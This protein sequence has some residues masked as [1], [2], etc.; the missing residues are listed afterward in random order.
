MDIQQAAALVAAGNIQAI[1]R[2]AAAGAWDSLTEDDKNTL[3]RAAARAGQAAMLRH[4]FEHHHMYATDPDPRGRTPLHFAA[5][6]GDEATVRFAVDVLG[7]DPLTGDADGRTAL[8]YAH[9]ADRQA[10]YAWLTR[11]LGFG[12][13]DAYRNPILRGFH[14]DPSILR[15]GEDYYIVNSSFVHFPGLPISHSRD[16]V[17]WQVIGHAA[18]DLAASGLAGLPGGYGYWA[19]D[20]SYYK[21]RFWV[22]AT[23]RRHTPP[24]RLQMITSAADPRGPWDKPRFLPLDGIDPS[25]FADDDGRRY[26]LLNPGAIIAEIDDRGELI[27]EPE[28]ISFGSARIKPEGP[29]LLK[30]DGWYYLFLAEGGT[31]SG[32]M[33]TAARSKFLRGPY[34]ACPFNPILGR[35]NPLSPIQRSGHGKPVMLPDGRWMFVYLCGRSVEGKTVM[36]RETALDPMTWTQDGW[37]MVNALKGPSCLQKKPL[38]DGGTAKERNDEW[39]S[40]RADPRAFAQWA[41]G[42]L[43]LLCGGDPASVAPSSV[44]LRRQTEKCFTQSVHVDM[45]DAAAG[46]AAGLTGYYDERSFFL[47]GIR[48]ETAR[49]CLVL[50]EQ[51]GDTRQERI[52]KELPGPAAALTVEG[53][54]FTRRLLCEN[55]EV[56]VFRAEYLCDEGVQGGKRFTGALVGVAAVGQGTAALNDYRDAMLPPAPK[57]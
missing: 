56:G 17:H 47:F 18:D 48:K 45:A 34:E 20:I 51:I 44:L 32:H 12:V 46:S 19:P 35:K 36:G 16:L 31:G 29:H 24:Y 33:E 41:G 26:I 53:D 22:V 39:V 28:M 49:Y 54:G 40:P 42:D 9:L 13:E 25:L 11:R 7:F 27:S 23:L 14:P 30:K 6:S 1:D 8:D 15:V 43:R 38:P 4:L 3:T 2:L 37:P 52:L 5:M 57:D 21:G 10:A 55:I 50:I